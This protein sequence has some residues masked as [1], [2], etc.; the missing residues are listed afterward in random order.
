MLGTFVNLY[1][2]DYHFSFF[3]LQMKW[4]A[5]SAAR[6]LRVFLLKIIHKLYFYTKILYTNCVTLTIP[7]IPNLL[8][9]Y[10]SYSKMHFFLQSC[11]GLFKINVNDRFT[12]QGNLEKVNSAISLEFLLF[13]IFECY[14]G[15]FILSR[16]LILVHEK[17]FLLTV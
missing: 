7:R 5:N 13:N 8:I 9:V 14:V 6:E 17:N 2:P 12:S 3:N 11:R 16:T 10:W 1:F 4:W 15:L